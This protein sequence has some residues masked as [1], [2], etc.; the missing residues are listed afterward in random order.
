MPEAKTGKQKSETK[1]IKERKI[2]GF[3]KIG[4]PSTVSSYF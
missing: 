3:T 4:L 2:L 1:P